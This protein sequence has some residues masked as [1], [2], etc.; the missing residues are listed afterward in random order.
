MAWIPNIFEIS[1]LMMSNQL[2]HIPITHI[3][4]RKRWQCTFVYGVNEHGGREEL[5][6]DLCKIGDVV[7]EAGII[8]GDFTYN[9]SNKKRDI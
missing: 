9:P 2:I 5:W 3:P 8:V 1:I 6:K 4:T 7:E